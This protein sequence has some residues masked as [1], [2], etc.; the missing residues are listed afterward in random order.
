MIYNIPGVRA[1]SLSCSGTWTA[2]EVS[3]EDVVAPLAGHGAAGD[4]FLGYF[5]CMD[6]S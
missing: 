2:D 4:G 5:L 1:G 6:G 3:V